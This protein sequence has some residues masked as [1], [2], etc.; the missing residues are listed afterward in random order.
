LFVLLFAGCAA[1]LVS[2]AKEVSRNPE[3]NAPKKAYAMNQQAK[4]GRFT[5]VVT[6]MRR[7]GHIADSL[8]GT[9][10]RGEFVVLTV[11]VANHGRSDAGRAARLGVLQRCPGR[12][13][14][15]GRSTRGPGPGLSVC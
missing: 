8:T 2:G 3:V 4:D 1:L 5:F 15:A 7:T 12:V 11:N 13:D 9:D 10:A 6:K 14:V